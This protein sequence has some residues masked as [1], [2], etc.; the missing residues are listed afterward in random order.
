MADQ[1]FLLSLEPPSC[2]VVPVRDLGNKFFSSSAITHSQQDSDSTLPTVLPI[3]HT[4]MD[5]SPGQPPAFN[6]EVRG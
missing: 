2:M 4:G 6:C 3:N 5:D 1:Q